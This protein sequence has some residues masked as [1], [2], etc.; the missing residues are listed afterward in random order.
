MREQDET[1][2]EESTGPERL[3]SAL[4]NTAESDLILTSLAASREK[5]A[6]FMNGVRFFGISA[7]LLVYL[8]N[9]LESSGEDPILNTWPHV[10]SYWIGATAL[11]FLS[12]RIPAVCHLSRFAVPVLDMPM[13]SWIQTKNIQFGI[14]EQLEACLAFA[15]KFGE[16]ALPI[17]PAE[18]GGLVERIKNGSFT[19]ED[20]QILDQL[21]G[22][23]DNFGAPETIATFTLATLVFLT[24]MSSLSL[25]TRYLIPT[26]LVGCLC[27]TMVYSRA[28]MV[29]NDGSLF[30]IILAL[31]LIVAT[32]AMMSWLP[33]RQAALIREAANR[34]ARRNRL[35]RYFS[36]GVAQY[37][38]DR[39]DPGAGEECEISVLFCDIRG[40][41]GLSEGLE[42]PEVVDLLNDFHGIMVEEIFGFGGTLDKFLGDGLLAWFNAPVR[43]PDHAVLAVK[44]ALSMIQS[45]ETLNRERESQGKPPLR[46]GI[47]IHSGKAVVGNI[48]AQHRKE[49]TAVGD[50][51]NVASRLESLTRAHDTDII[52]SDSV[53][54]RIGEPEP[55][56]LSFSSCGTAEIRGRQQPVSIYAPLEA[57]SPSS[58]TGSQPATS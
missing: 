41:T 52:V 42:A 53:L 3:S 8:Y 43:Q 44:C 55:H 5:N 18:L 33:R 50:T 40:F 2:V 9:F 17:P 7:F 38:E 13:V 49:F 19:A 24:A 6:Q 25:R 21:A 11:W 28:G 22:D 58:E 30:S 31:V 1:D 26:T 23:L 15:R 48:G 4:E 35:A 46:V 34:Q 54:R 47:G 12:R 29:S 36:P 10:V 27:V 57:I 20:L 16:N 39:D 45:L 56:G 51:V 37:I 14:G 32:A